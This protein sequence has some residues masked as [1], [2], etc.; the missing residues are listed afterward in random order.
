[1]TMKSP[2]LVLNKETLNLLSVVNRQKPGRTTFGC[3]GA[4]VTGP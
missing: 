3:Q 4:S 2:K 1:M